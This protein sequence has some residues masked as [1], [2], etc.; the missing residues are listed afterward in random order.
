MREPVPAADIL[1]AS[2]IDPASL[3]D[4]MPRVDPS[5]VKVQVASKLF[6]R[7]W[8]K[9]IAAVALPTGIFVQPA[10]WVTLGLKAVAHAVAGVG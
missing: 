7:F 2:G 3:A 8:A 4:V 10:V 9:G 6:R 1:L 5:Q